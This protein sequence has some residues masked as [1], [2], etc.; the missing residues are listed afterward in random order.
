MNDQQLTQ[1]QQ[2]IQDLFYGE[3]KMT[4]NDI[5]TRHAVTLTRC[6]DE[7]ASVLFV[8][9]VFR[10][11]PEDRVSQMTL[12]RIMAHAREKAQ[13][14]ESK[15]SVWQWILRPVLSFGSAGLAML[16]VL[17]LW[18]HKPVQNST[19]QVAGADQDAKLT[20]VVADAS[21]SVKQRLLETPFD[22]KNFQDRYTVP[23]KTRPYYN[24]LVSSV[25][26]GNQDAS[27]YSM[28]DDIDQKILSGT[29]EQQDLQTLYYRAVRLEKQGYIAEALK[30][31]EFL[32]QNYPQF[33]YRQAIPLAMARCFEQLGEKSKALSFVQQYE[34]QYGGSEDL[35]LWKDQLKSETF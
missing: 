19:N 25:S 30:D 33:E 11:L 20:P 28:L 10:E 23:S 2:D 21:P 13:K 6:Q 34:S 4:L 9:R 17:A 18:N 24:S 5:A 15:A 3:S 8:S 12:N 35:N 16:L 22:G 27:G 26:V 32:A 29:L 31:Y 7:L 14:L 1:F